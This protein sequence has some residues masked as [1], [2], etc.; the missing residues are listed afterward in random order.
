MSSPAGLR[1]NATLK[2]VL[3]VDHDVVS[4]F[5][6]RGIISA[7]SFQRLD[8][9]QLA[10]KIFADPRLWAW[11]MVVLVILCC[12]TALCIWPQSISD[13]FHAK[14]IMS[15]HSIIN[16]FVI[17]VISLCSA[18][19]F[20]AYISGMCTFQVSRHWKQHT[21]RHLIRFG[22]THVEFEWKECFAKKVRFDSALSACRSYRSYDTEVMLLAV[23]SFRL[24]KACAFVLRVYLITWRR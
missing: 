5:K 14:F 18:H 15:T 3:R 8:D 9:R 2:Q 23:S 7:L 4:R 11:I 19:C 10:R 16:A 6:S 21:Q 17:S 20:C 1:S 24:P 12:G 22:V 13:Y